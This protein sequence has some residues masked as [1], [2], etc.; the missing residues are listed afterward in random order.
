VLGSPPARCFHSETN[1]LGTQHGPAAHEGDR[2]GA[3]A[4]GQAWTASSSAATF[5]TRLGSTW[6]PGPIV[7]ETVI[8]LM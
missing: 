1:G 5:L 8:F 2:A 4:V 6:M 7:V 3:A